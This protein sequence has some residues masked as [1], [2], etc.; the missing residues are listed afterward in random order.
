MKKSIACIVYDDGKILIAHRNPVGD[1]GGRWEFPGGK[2]EPGEDEKDSIAR[3]MMEEF[4]VVAEAK[5]K[6]SSIQ[7][8]HRGEVFTL[9]A[10][11]VVFEHNGMEKSFTL[12]EHTE[13]KW[14][15][16]SSVPDYEFVD[17]DLKIYPSV[18]EFLS[19]L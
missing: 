4:G 6:I 5:E 16:A 11:L 7:F 15:N 19:A 2:V 3:E 18:L 9:D 1:M 10:Y 8:E 17:S 14:I 12:S 13:Y